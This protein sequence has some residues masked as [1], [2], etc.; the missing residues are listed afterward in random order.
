MDKPG[1][2]ETERVQQ[3]TNSEWLAEYEGTDY[4]SKSVSH[5]VIELSSKLANKDQNPFLE[6]IKKSGIAS[7]R[8][9][10]KKLLITT[11]RPITPDLDS[12]IKQSIQRLAE[13][14]EPDTGEPLYEYME[15][16][17]FFSD[18]KPCL[19]V[20]F[21]ELHTGE[22]AE[23]YFNIELRKCLSGKSV[24]TGINGE[25]RVAGSKRLQEGMFLKFWLEAVKFI[26]Y[27]RKSQI[28]RYMNSKLS[29]VVVSCPN[30]E[31]RHNKITKLKK[32]KYEGHIYQIL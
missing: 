17:T 25:F 15:Y 2:S 1:L 7:I 20:V 32:L 29:G 11:D 4:K 6:S 14:A 12:R 10:G 26:P 22:I 31:Q 23:R 18:K 21:Q 8:F 5:P 9:A 27:N 13:I 30:P 19:A 24:K 28:Y 3:Q 16:R